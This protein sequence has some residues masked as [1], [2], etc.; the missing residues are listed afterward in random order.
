MLT[1]ERLVMILAL[2]A[3]FYG[4]KVYLYND[5][6]TFVSTG[7]SRTFLANHRHCYTTK[8]NISTSFELDTLT[9]KT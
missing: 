2:F 1:F 9:C 5:L 4:S 6:G 7:D 3:P 8:V